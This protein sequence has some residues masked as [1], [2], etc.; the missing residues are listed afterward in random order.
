V[1]FNGFGGIIL[2][3][4]VPPPPAE[5]LV[6]RIKAP[7]S[8]GDFLAVA[9]KSEALGEETFPRVRVR[10]DHVTDVGGGWKR[11]TVPVSELNPEGVSYDRIV[12]QAATSVG[13]DWVLLDQIALTGG[14]GTGPAAVR[15][16]G[17]VQLS[18][19]CDRPTTR[20]NP[21]IYAIAAGVWTTGETAHRVGGNP[22][23]RLN[24]D[25]GNLWNAGSDW[26]FENVQADNG[27]W[28]WID[29]TFKKGVKM[30]VVVPM[31]GWVAKDGTSVGF[32]KSRFPE[33]RKFDQHRPEAGDGFRPDGA[34][35]APGPPTLTSVAAPPAKIREWVQKARQLDAAR[36]GRGIDMYMLDN[37]PGLWDKTHRD[38]HPDPVGYDELLDRT[39]Q[40]GTAIRSADPDAVI[41]GPTV[42]GWPQYFT[43]SKDRRSG[44]M[45]PD[46]VMHGGVPLLAW[47]L[48]KLA[49]HERKTGVR[50]LDVLDVHYY[51]QAEGVGSSRTDAATAALRLRS[52]RSLWDPAYEDESWINDNI[53]L[54]PRLKEWIAEN[55]PGRGISLGEWSFGAEGHISGGLATAEALGRFGQY[56]LTSAFY[57]RS[58]K[59]GTPAY[60]G[61]RACHNFA[62]QGG[63]FRDLSVPT[64]EAK[65]VSLFASR[66]EDGSHLTLIVLNRDPGVAVQASV[67]IATCGTASSAR[68]YQYSGGKAGF[69]EKP[70]AGK[71]GAS[72]GAALPPY[73]IT[74][75]DL[76]VSGAR[77]K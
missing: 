17:T 44:L 69:V 3:R 75:L 64:T 43:S 21:M 12:L 23:T 73:S 34:P 29:E 32:P 76:A 39:I 45:G 16:G 40:Y 71:A 37:E 46:R 67:D 42:W 22:M 1:K 56:G 59:E 15:S 68:A 70:P 41:A 18:V 5:Q 55:Y 66:D 25:R 54:I 4:R 13:G 20:I 52:T 60:H 53:Q 61:F 47:Y 35:I 7:S 57:W 31:I 77:G 10:P 58:L 14:S 33:Q 6:F 74:V 28:D 48:R 24:W 36:G 63:R 2:K 38:V 72:V 27:I 26:F 30:A 62:G 50:I 8:Y 9:F 65:D 49:E 51:P 19:R 11:I